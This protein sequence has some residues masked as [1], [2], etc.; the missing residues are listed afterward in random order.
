[1]PLNTYMPRSLPQIN[2]LWFLR[3]CVLVAQLCLTLCNPVDCGSPGPSIHGTLQAR[4][5]EWVTISYSILRVGP[6]I[7]NVHRWFFLIQCIVSTYIWITY[8]WFR[9]FKTISKKAM[10]SNCD[11]NIQ[12]SGKTLWSSSSHNYFSSFPC[13][14]LPNTRAGEHNFSEWLNAA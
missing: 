2:Q 14:L 7:C 12:K 11:G 1:M 8:V 10:S 3:V 5:L 4:K 13:P 9:E 6:I